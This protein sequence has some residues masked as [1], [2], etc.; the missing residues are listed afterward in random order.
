VFEIAFG[1]WIRE[2]EERSPAEINAE[3]LGELLT[4]AQFSAPD[5]SH[6]SRV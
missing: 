5:R 6:R 4:L 3:V 2:G 1:Q